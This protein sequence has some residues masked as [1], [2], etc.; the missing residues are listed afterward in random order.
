MR[1]KQDA[2]D[3]ELGVLEDKTESLALR[4]KRTERALKKQTR[5][6][7]KGGGPPEPLLLHL[8]YELI[9]EI[10]IRLRPS[11]LFAVQRACKPLR[12]CVLAEEA[13]LA[14]AVV[15]ARY[16]CLAECYRLPVPAAALDA[17]V[18]AMLADPARQAARLGLLHDGKAN[19]SSSYYSSSHYQHVPP[20][21]P[22][23][24]CTC[25]TCQLRWTAL[26]VAVDFAHWQ[27]H[28]DRG[29]AIPMVPRGRA[30]QWNRDLLAAHAAVLRRALRSPLWHAR[31]LEAHLD[32]TTRSIRRH[33]AN[34]GNR[35]RRFRMTR[36]DVESGTDRF[37]ERSGPPSHDFPYHRDNY[38]LLEA[39]LPNRGWNGEA[40]RW[41]YLPANQHDRDLDFVVRAFRLS[42]ASI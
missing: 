24:V 5:R 9:F 30:P 41:V 11:D 12:R 34:K 33:A 39:Y 26:G 32:S 22:A 23:E 40:S 8:P 14:A 42:K 27:G 1:R 35:R 20:A 38:Y 16:A 18:R 29:E 28:L 2:E 19:S 13:R 36:D 3:E 37:L 15:G 10:L 25:L 17:G 21:D 7:E 31:L 6:A 4:S